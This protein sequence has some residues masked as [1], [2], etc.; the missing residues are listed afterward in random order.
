MVFEVSLSQWRIAF[1]SG[2][3]FYYLFIYASFPFGTS[4]NTREEMIDVH[5]PLMF[6]SAALL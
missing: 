6:S 3:L 1:L 4:L 5:V 2:V